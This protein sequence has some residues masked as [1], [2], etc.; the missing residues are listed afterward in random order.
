MPGQ[1]DHNLRAVILRQRGTNQ[2]N[3]K[4][5]TEI[6]EKLSPESKL[7]LYHLLEDLQHQVG[8]ER[9]KRRMGLVY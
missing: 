3:H 7:A 9:K 4:L 8:N 2:N 1:L 5:A 6:L